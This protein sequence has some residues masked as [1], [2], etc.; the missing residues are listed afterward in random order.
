MVNGVVTISAPIAEVDNAE[1]QA[2]KV[3]AGGVTKA[4]LFSTTAYTDTQG[5]TWQP[6]T[7]L[8]TTTIDS[9]TIA[10]VTAGTPMLVL[11]SGTSISDGLAKQL[12]SAGAFNYYGQVGDSRASWMGSWIFLK[13]HP[14]YNGLPTNSTATAS[15]HKNLSMN[16]LTESATENIPPGRKAG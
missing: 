4:Y 3:V 10:A 14:A 5:L 9:D 12:A 16:S 11:A 8:P 2:V 13:D 6:Y 1:F 15:P 7:A